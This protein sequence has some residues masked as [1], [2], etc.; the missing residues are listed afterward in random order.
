M[1]TF[2]EADLGAVLA[3]LSEACRD[4]EVEVNAA[5]A[6]ALSDDAD[7]TLPLPPAGSFAADT[8]RAAE[9]GEWHAVS[10][11]LQSS[12]CAPLELAERP[13]SSYAPAA[14][15][16][17]SAIEAILA[18]K[19]RLSKA[20]SS[21]TQE[22]DRSTQQ[23]ALREEAR[24]LADE[25]LSECQRANTG[26]EQQLEAAQARL[27]KQRQAAAAAASEHERSAASQRQKLATL[28]HQLK[29][30]EAET[31]RLQERLS[32]ELGERDAA[33]KQRERQVFQEVH[34]RAYRPH[35]AADSRSLEVISV[36]ESQR[37]DMNVELDELR[38]HVRELSDELAQKENL[39][40]RKDAY[41]S[42]RTPDE[43]AMLAKVQDAQRE[44][45][46][47]R[48]ELV[49]AESRHTEQ[50]RAARHAAT[51]AQHEAEVERARAATLQL[52]LSSRPTVRQL[53]D[54][55]ATIEQLRAALPLAKGAGPAELLR[56]SSKGA[57]STRDPLPVDSSEAI[58]RDREVHE[59]PSPFAD[60]WSLPPCRALSSPAHTPPRACT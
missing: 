3:S 53:T 51:E 16:L 29:A 49:A 1:A 13:S 24:R 8:S 11:L 17:R 35:S 38:A 27:E 23:L 41:H 2:D 25:R 39:I 31:Q 54:A 44:A 58:R 59:P 33:Q 60:P 37:R 40:A 34:R 22:A 12:G 55:R 5:C 21:A 20:L 46:A 14:T 18:D 42:W 19:E 10:R 7:A 15:A 43:G 52:D 30:K 45:N 56:P 50:L 57:P 48:E 32:R 28:G 9:A 6:R 47:A 36:Y 4:A 26:L